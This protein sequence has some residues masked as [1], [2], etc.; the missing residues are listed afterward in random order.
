MPRCR[1]KSAGNIL[2]GH[3]PTECYLRPYGSG[4][5]PFGGMKSD[6]YF[7]DLVTLSADVDAIGGILYA[8]TL[9]VVVFG[10]GLIG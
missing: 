4:L 6:D 2:A 7:F 8:D 10:S 3:W 1:K 9:K 5:R